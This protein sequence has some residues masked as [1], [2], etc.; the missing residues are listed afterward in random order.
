M[1]PINKM[2]KILHSSLSL[3]LIMLLLFNV[4]SPKVYAAEDGAEEEEELLAPY[5]IIQN[6]DV[7]V[8]LFPLK[9]T[10]VTANINGIIAEV[11][12]VQ[13]YAN[14]GEEPI[15]ARYVFPTSSGVTMH[16]MRMEIGDN[17]VTAQIR[18]K[19]EA[20]EVYEEAKSEGKS[21]SLLEQKRPNVFTMD[22]ANIM[23]GDA[24][25]IELH[26]TELISPTEGIY[27][28][29]FPTVVGPRYAEV[30]QAP[31]LEELSSPRAESRTLRAPG[32]G[33]TADSSGSPADNDT[34]NS[35]SSAGKD[36]DSA[37]SST[38]ES[39]GDWLSSPY[40]AEGEL[41]P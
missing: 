1:N 14:E 19:E 15:N 9:S 23:P 40:L 20:K 8:D 26:Y 34:D 33:K 5:F 38:A 37:G 11:Y 22:V 31:A 17:V 29:V 4:Y 7:P 32:S 13:T 36:A 28:F 35:G 6:E 30:P 24:A 16:G 27:E 10:E 25:R 12:V 18:E 21:A 2:S 39:D 3:L 41:P